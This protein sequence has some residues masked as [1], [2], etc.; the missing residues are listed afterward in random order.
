MDG[1]VVG[2][3]G[4]VADPVRQVVT[5]QYVYTLDIDLQESSDAII[6][7]TA[8]GEDFTAVLTCWYCPH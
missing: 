1:Q 4:L 6:P 8:A 3:Y 2:D 7:N 5:G